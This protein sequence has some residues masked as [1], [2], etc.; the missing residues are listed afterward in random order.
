MIFALYGLSFNL[1]LLQLALS[2]QS[3]FFLLFGLLADA[4]DC[5]LTFIGVFEW[6]PDH[7]LQL[8]VFGCVC[9]CLIFF[10][11]VEFESLLS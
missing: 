6:S 4:F 3:H 1:R 5:H 2:T 7:G 10:E 9:D 11:F 8:P